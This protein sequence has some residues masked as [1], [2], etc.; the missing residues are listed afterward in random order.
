[1]KTT[2]RRVREPGHTQKA[3]LATTVFLTFLVPVLVTPALAGG[4][5]ASDTNSSLAVNAYGGAANGTVLKLVSNCTPN[6]PDCTWTYRNGMLLSDTNPT[7]AVNAY[8][9]AA[10]G[11]VLKLVDNCTPNN[12]D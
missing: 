5:L 9:G 12:T 11:V 4:M 2:K 10:D 7:L 6:N 1:M 3:N 8:G